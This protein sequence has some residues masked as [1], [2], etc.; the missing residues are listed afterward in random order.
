MLHQIM[1][2]SGESTGPKSG[3]GN[4]RSPVGMSVGE[5]SLPTWGGVWGGK[6]VGNNSKSTDGHFGI[7]VG[8]LR[9]HWRLQLWGTG[10]RAPPRLIFV[11]FTV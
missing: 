5:I 7:N 3:V 1:S 4:R 8:K 9:V 10:A 11:Q 2:R 6:N